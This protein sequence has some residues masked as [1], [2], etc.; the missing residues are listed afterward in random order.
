[1]LDGKR[2]D[3]IKKKHRNGYEALRNTGLSELA[4]FY[5]ISIIDGAGVDWDPGIVAAV[6]LYLQAL[7]EI[8]FPTEKNAVTDVDYLIQHSSF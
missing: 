6:R 8:G 3:K 5:V 4:I 1:M 2:V 7:K